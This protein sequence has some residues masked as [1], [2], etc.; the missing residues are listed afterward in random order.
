MSDKV[1]I[2]TNSVTKYFPMKGK[3]VKALSKVS[4]ELRH[5]EVLGCVGE[6]GSGKSTLGKVL[7]GLEEP[8]SGYVRIYDTD[9]GQLKQQDPKHLSSL[10]QYI[11]QDP[12]SSLNPRMT[13]AEIIAEPLMVHGLLTKDA[14]HERVAELLQL[15]DLDPSEATKYPHELSGGQKQRIGI[16][17]ALSLNP[18]ILICDEPISALDVI[19]AESI[20]SLF[21]QLHEK[22]QFACLFISHDLLRTKAV[23]D[24]ISVMFFGHFV[25]VAESDEL[26]TAPKHPY[27]H[28]LIS[29]IPLSKP[30]SGSQPSLAHHQEPAAK[31]CVYSTSC[32]YAKP[33]CFEKEP[34][35]I[36]LSDTHQV[37]CHLYDERF[38]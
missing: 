3:V 7:M 15:V 2:K 1:L 37:A 33:V 27:T 8:S 38:S 12:S 36:S 5:G 18:K 16:A 14:M 4:I 17:R 26:F 6:S 35:L 13:I 11:F 30:D 28:A 24:R 22:N 19:T 32:P 9:L 31:G 10:I 20:L 23:C 29:S 34:K 21:R 25:E